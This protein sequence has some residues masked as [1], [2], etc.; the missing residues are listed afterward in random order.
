MR[1]LL[2]ND[3]FVISMGKK[4]GRRACRSGN[5]GR[6]FRF[7]LSNGML[8]CVLPGMGSGSIVVHSELLIWEFSLQYGKRGL[9]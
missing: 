8:I 5:S 4:T 3:P 7:F 6:F 2:E 1:A 9:L